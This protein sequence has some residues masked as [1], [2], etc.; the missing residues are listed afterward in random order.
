MPKKIINTLDIG[1]SCILC[2]QA[3]YD[4]KSTKT[5][6][7]SIQERKTEG[8]QKGT[9][10]NKKALEYCVLRTVDAVE[11]DS[12]QRFQN[13]LV[14]FSSPN[15]KSNLL[16]VKN[17]VDSVIT[18]KKI[19]HLS[20]TLINTT[21]QETHLLHMIPLSYT[22]DT[23]KGVRDPRGMQASTLQGHFHTISTH[24]NEIDVLS[25]IL[26]DSKLNIQA[27]VASPFASGLGASVQDERD[28]G[29][30]VLDIG[31][32][33]TGISA[34]YEGQCMHVSTIPLGGHYVTHDISCIIG[35]SN[36][37]AERIKRLHGSALPTA[38]HSHTNISVNLANADGECANILSTYLTNIIR[39]R[40]Q[41]IFLKT[42]EHLKN[43]GLKTRHLQRAIITGGVALTPRIKDLASSVLQMQVRVSTPN[44]FK[45]AHPTSTCALGMIYFKEQELHK[46]HMILPNTSS[47]WNI[48][49]KLH[50]Y[51]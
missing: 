43:N 18:T 33:F 48:M 2:T 41:E 10:T 47:W 42:A 51:R 49:A 46:L 14:N 25:K 12:K 17:K 6:I 9:I 5:E 29:V 13:I 40:L 44:A 1:S 4:S 36:A 28:I 30:I 39:A 32:H 34:F 21:L 22:V 23:Y 8:F 7:I 26:Y 50:R 19:L 27:F 38:R 11:K 35:C 24:K 16:T 45:N 31:A 37:N 15:I 3:L 20:K